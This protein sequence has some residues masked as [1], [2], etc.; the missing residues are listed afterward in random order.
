MKKWFLALAALVMLAVPALADAHEAGPA[1]TGYKGDVTFWMKDA[2]SKLLQLADAI[3]EGKFSWKPAKD[4]RTVSEVFMHVAGANY[5][6]PMM[7]GVM[8]PE[9]VGIKSPADVMAFD[10]SKTK[11]A[12]VVRALKESFE[13]MQSAYAAASEESLNAE[14]DLMGMKT[15][16]RGI[17]VLLL[18][19]AHEHLGQ[20]IAYAR[21]V[22]V[23]PPW[24]AIQNAAFEKRMKEMKAE[25]TGRE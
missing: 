5:G 13:H 9:A 23:A 10:K 16:A 24:T 3:P 8:P 4:T 11:K 19:H 20:A 18:S 17:Y 2:E 6:M 12:D 7:T 15:T 25:S 1:A 21:S 22:G 14:A